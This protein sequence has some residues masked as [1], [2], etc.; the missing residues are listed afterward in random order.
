M[1]T[2]RSRETKVTYQ[3]NHLYLAI[4]ITVLAAITFGYRYSFVSAPGKRLASRIPAAL[5]SLLA[6]ATFAA[7]IVNSLLAQRGAP[8]FGAKLSVA[9]LSLVVAYWTRSMLGT[10]AF[11]LGLLYAWAH[12]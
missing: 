9:A 1:E 4:G 2:V 3:P 11:G 12:L 10:L 5:L 6:P 8:D 7:I